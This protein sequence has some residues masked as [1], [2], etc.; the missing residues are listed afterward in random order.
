[1]IRHSL[2][3][4]VLLATAGAA[5]AASDPGLKAGTYEIDPSH[6]YGN[7]EV[8]HMGLSTMHGRI[9]VK[10]GTIR[11]APNGGDSQVSVTLDPASVNTGNKARDEHL[12]DMDGFFNV[13][14][15]PSMKFESTSVT[16]DDDDDA[17]EATVEGNLTMHGVTRPVTLD[18]DDIACRINPLEKSKYTCGF[19]AETKLKRSDYGIDAYLLLVGDEIE[20]SIEVEAGQPIDATS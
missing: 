9:D 17:D 12:R 18:V 14:K 10:S 4:G 3:F 1:M 6:T 15:H 11:I 13:K 8:G 2:L 20:L 7:F 5:S 19:S 16:F